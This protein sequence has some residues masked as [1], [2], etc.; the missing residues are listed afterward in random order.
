MTLEVWISFRRPELT[1][2]GVA[3]D[4]VYPECVYWPCEAFDEACGFVLL[5]Q[6]TAEGVSELRGNGVGEEQSGP[7]DSLPQ[8]PA[9]PQEWGALVHTRVLHNQVDV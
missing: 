5:P 7:P 9:Q 6:Q 4:N 1:L 3:E 2:D 8:T